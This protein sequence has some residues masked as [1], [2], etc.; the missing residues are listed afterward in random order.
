MGKGKYNGTKTHLKFRKGLIAVQAAVRLLSLSRTQLT[1]TEKQKVKG[2]YDHSGGMTGFLKIREV[3]TQLGQVLTDNEVLELM[4][5]VEYKEGHILTFYSFTRMMELLK[6]R[7]LI[8]ST[9]DTADAFVALGGQRDKSGEIDARQLRDTVKQFGLTLDID[10]LIEEVDS[11]GS[12]MIDFDEFQ[13]IFDTANSRRD[14]DFL[15]QATKGQSETALVG[16]WW[17]VGYQVHPSP[18]KVREEEHKRDFGASI[19]AGSNHHGHAHGRDVGHNS[20]HSTQQLHHHIDGRFDEVQSLDSSEGM[21]SDSM[22]VMQAMVSAPTRA[23]GRSKGKSNNQG[24][25]RKDRKDKF[26]TTQSST[27]SKKKVNW[28]TSGLNRGQAAGNQKTRESSKAAASAADAEE[29]YD[30]ESFDYEEERMLYESEGSMMG[31]NKLPRIMFG[32]NGRGLAKVSMGIGPLQPPSTLAEQFRNL[33]PSADSFLQAAAVMEPDHIT[34]AGAPGSAPAPV[35]GKS[36]YVPRPNWQG[37]LNNYTPAQKL[38][39]W[40]L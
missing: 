19:G 13:F 6:R 37:K 39:R 32:P 3:L 5:K 1:F 7:H 33:C 2:I 16:G 12:G 9:S 10:R 24:S 38:A 35:E 20:T 11:D 29:D 40:T 26:N 14:S 8:N 28:M 36:Q 25:N 18:D 17:K 34:K 30:P 4:N 21:M 27:G 31:N 23:V 15:T 22:H